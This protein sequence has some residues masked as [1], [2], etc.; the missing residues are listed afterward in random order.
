MAKDKTPEELVVPEGNPMH[1]L[2]RPANPKY[3]PNIVP[4]IDVLF[5]LLLFFLLSTRFRQ[6]EGDIPGSLPAIGQSP[7]GAAASVELRPIQI[8]LR[9]V[10]EM[11]DT[12]A[13]ELS[14]MST[15]LENADRL[16]EALITRIKNTSD[17]A[18]VVIKPDANVRWQ[19][20]VEA[21]NAAIRA[22]AKNVGFAPA[23]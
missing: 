17:E 12:C 16:Y 11:R 8:Q 7:E 3:Q 18:P 22:H 10:G 4:L 15:T 2:L 21:F 1:K 9:P 20:V 6:Q 5:M 23:G 14:G 13:Y 19:F